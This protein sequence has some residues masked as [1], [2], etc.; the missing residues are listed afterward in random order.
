MKNINLLTTFIITDHLYNI[1]VF[2]IQS[3]HT[4]DQVWEDLCRFHET[5]NVVIIMHLKNKLQS[6]KMKEIV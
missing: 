5:K 1:V 2:H 6:L 3:C 4:F